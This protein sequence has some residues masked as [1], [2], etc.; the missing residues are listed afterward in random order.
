MHNGL[1]SNQ[2]PRSIHS[3]GQSVN[4]SVVNQWQDPSQQTTFYHS[5]QPAFSTSSYDPRV[6]LSH[7]LQTPVVQTFINCDDLYLNETAKNLNNIEKHECC[8]L[9]NNPSSG[10]LS[11]YK[12]QVID[13]D[14]NEAL[15]L[16]HFRLLKTLTRPEFINQECLK[17]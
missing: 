2:L 4:A 3:Y 1:C 6:D 10:L 11:E 9:F 17:G 14:T 15:S 13:L 16:Q 12:T 5:G 8:S 7:L